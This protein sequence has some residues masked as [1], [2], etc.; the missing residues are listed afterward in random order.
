MHKSEKALCRLL[1]ARRDP[2]VLLEPIEEAFDHVALLVQAFGPVALG[3]AVALRRNDCQRRLGFYL[4]D[5]RVAVVALVA[6]DGAGCRGLGDQRRRF[7]TVVDVARRDRDLER[8][9]RRI[10]ARMELGG[11]ASTRKANSCSEGPPFAPALCW[12][13]R[14]YEPSMEFQ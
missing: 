2:S 4:C 8:L 9:S 12:C 14:T 13:A 3:L 7:G 11:T 5:H 6:D 1:V 10:N